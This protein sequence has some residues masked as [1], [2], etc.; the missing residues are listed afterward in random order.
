MAESIG[1]CLLVG[2]GT[3]WLCGLS[4]SPVIQTVVSSVLAI[5]GVLI[6]TLVGTTEDSQARLP[7]INPWP[8]VAFVLALGIAA[9][10]G[11][12]ARLY[13]SLDMG[14][15]ATGAPLNDGSAAQ[16]AGKRSN[17]SASAQQFGLYAGK[18]PI[19]DCDHIRTA[20]PARLREQFQVAEND[21]LR[22]IGNAIDSVPLL[23]EISELVC[24]R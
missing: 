6:A 5:S 20:E 12:A 16:V 10:L 22:D 18:D 21:R 19:K 4:L 1:A 9:P 11:V 24:R 23:T 17:A 13:W 3:G 7:R 14:S 15:R 8:L 2:L